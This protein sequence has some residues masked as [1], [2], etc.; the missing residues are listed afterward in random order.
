M[1]PQRS[2][3]AYVLR[4]DSAPLQLCFLAL[5]VKIDADIYLRIQAPHTSH[6]HGPLRRKRLLYWIEMA[7]GD[8]AQRS[9]EE[10]RSK[11]R[12]LFSCARTKR[13]EHIFHISHSIPSS[14]I[15]LESRYNGTDELLMV[16]VLGYTGGGI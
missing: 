7:G 11:G 16:V 5:N 4:H 10:S 6:A 3:F 15:Q 13:Y 8:A 9:S 14:S 12:Q 1:A 2:I